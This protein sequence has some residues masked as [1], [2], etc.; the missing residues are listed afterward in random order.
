MKRL[1]PAALFTLAFVFAFLYGPST[2][3]H[4]AGSIGQGAPVHADEAN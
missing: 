2:V 1:I 3:I 4:E